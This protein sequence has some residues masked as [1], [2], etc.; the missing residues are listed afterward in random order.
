MSEVNYREKSLSSVVSGFGKYE[1]TGVEHKIDLDTK[2]TKQDIYNLLVLIKETLDPEIIYDLYNELTAHVNNF[3]N[4]HHVTWDD[5]DTDVLTEL[6]RA[7]LDRGNSGEFLDFVSIL[8]QFIQ[9][10]SLEETLE[11]KSKT[12]LTSVY[13]VAKSIEL[14]NE[15]E[16]SHE[17][18]VESLFGG[19]PFTCLNT[20]FV[21]P[22][23]NNESDGVI[24]S[25]S[26]PITFVDQNGYLKDMPVNV[27]ES[28]YSLG[29]PSFPIFGPDKNLITHS[30]TDNDMEF[31]G[32][33]HMANGQ[34]KLMYKGLRSAKFVLEETNS[35]GK[36]SLLHGVKHRLENVNGF[37]NFSF[38]AKKKSSKYIY[39][40]LDGY[41]NEV[42][43]HENGAFINLES[44]DILEKKFKRKGANTD[45]EVV[46][47]TLANNTFRIGAGACVSEGC[48]RVEGKIFLVDDST[49]RVDH[50]AN[51]NSVFVSGF[52]MTDKPYM[53]PYIKTT[54]SV[55]SRSPMN[56]HML[57]NDDNRNPSQ[58]SFGIAGFEMTSLPHE[59]LA[60]FV[61]VVRESSSGVSFG[62]LFKLVNKTSGNQRK[63]TIY[64]N[65]NVNQYMDEEDYPYPNTKPN[66]YAFGYGAN[67]FSYFGYYS[68][69]DTYHEKQKP[70]NKQI[71]LSPTKMLIGRSDNKYLNGFL[72]KIIYYPSHGTRKN[73]KFLCSGEDEYYSDSFKTHYFKK[74]R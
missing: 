19:E 45:F 37:V 20:L 58:G 6:Y 54:G 31:F 49:M 70:Y 46:S 38:F 64:V 29:F 18:L 1:T 53:S 68:S 51:G 47:V 50:V 22:F 40:A 48:N 13:D 74:V 8:F 25:H 39:V 65:D 62:T 63:T 2:I 73:L 55:K 15:S 9:V 16:N 12:K 26:S 42:L 44:G 69:S 33:C 27:L 32:D 61:E 36:D 5:L 4:P 56:L 72:K 21:D 57:L 14:H 59:D 28:D 24:C 17:V 52:Q 7:W 41:M 30:E 34:T 71:L 23:L 35:S 66:G 10:A 3:Q 11:G 60:P 67:E 43:I